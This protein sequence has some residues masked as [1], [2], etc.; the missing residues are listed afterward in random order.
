MDFIELRLTLFGCGSS[1]I[2]RSAEV[3][4][5]TIADEKIF[6][7]NLVDLQLSDQGGIAK[8]SKKIIFA[9]FMLS[10]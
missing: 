8:L 6:E 1:E 3:D 2:S 7:L 4:Q 9:D 10:Y 5:N